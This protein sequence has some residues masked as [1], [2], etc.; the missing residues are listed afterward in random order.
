MASKGKNKRKVPYTQVDEQS[1]KIIRDTIFSVLINEAKEPDKISYIMS[2]FEGIG[3][4]MG[5]SMG[6]TKTFITDGLK[7]GALDKAKKLSFRRAKTELSHVKRLIDDLDVLI[8]QIHSISNQPEEGEEVEE[9]H[10]SSMQPNSKGL[11]QQGMRQAKRGGG[12]PQG[13]HSSSMQPK[14]KGLR[15]Q[16]KKKGEVEEARG[17]RRGNVRSKHLA[18][19]VEKDW[20][21]KAEQIITKK[22]PSRAGKIDWDTLKYL[23][24]TNASPE[25][26]AEKILRNK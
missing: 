15:Q 22:D 5:V 1:H 12:Q 2:L 13:G 21:R 6:Y 17:S 10:S 11:R 3:R 26:A 18:G 24:G 8:E 4:Q 7:M 9:G 16:G 19:M 14:S 20:M 23:H 25:E